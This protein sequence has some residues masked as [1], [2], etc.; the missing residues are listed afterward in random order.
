[1]SDT[2]PTIGIT[3]GDPAGIGPEIVVK[4]LADPAVRKLARFVVFGM[5]ELMAYA[6]DLAEIDPF[7]WRVQHDNARIGPDMVADVTVLDYDEYS[8][9]GQAEHRATRQGGEASMAFLNDAIEAAQLPERNPGRLDAIV[10]GP[11]CKQS[12]HMAGYTKYPGH[13]ELFQARTHSRRS[14]MMFCSPKLN[15]ALATIHLPL[16]DIRNVL[17]IGRVFDPIDLGHQALLAMGREDPVIAV[18][19]LNPHASEHG[20]FGDEESRLIEPAITMAREQGIDARGPFPADTLFIDAARGRYDLVV[21]MYHDQGLIP[22]KMLAFEEAVN[23]TLGLPIIR[24]SVD[25]GTAFDI[26]GQNKAN[27]NPM[28]AAIRLAFDMAKSKL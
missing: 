27:E 22:L 12:W 25:H 6:A 3:M 9:L 21:A 2:R 28:K 4:A 7:W 14:V 23:V 5:N 24:T 26:V 16:M 8:L 1:M 13:T 20:L 18:C 19:G 10:T 17:T 15:V 11:I